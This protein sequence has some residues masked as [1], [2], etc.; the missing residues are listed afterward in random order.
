MGI[1]QLNEI[2]FYFY[3]QKKTSKRVDNILQGNRHQKREYVCVY[4][5]ITNENV[6]SQENERKDSS[7]INEMVNVLVCSAKDM[8]I[9]RLFT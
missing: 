2:F 6:K 1:G 4:A 5:M 9:D 7:R 8:R 3:T